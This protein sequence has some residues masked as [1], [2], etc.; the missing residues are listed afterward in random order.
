MVTEYSGEDRAF[1]RRML[2]KYREQVAD[3]ER[4]LAEA[5][6]GHR[7][8]LSSHMARARADLARWMATAEE[9]GVR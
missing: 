2:K 5:P 1:C 6:R 4:R 3:Y 8:G 9:I 7:A